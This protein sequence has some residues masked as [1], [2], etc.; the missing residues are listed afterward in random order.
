MASP[1]V[2]F[3]DSGSC[4]LNLVLGGG[5]AVG[6][7]VNICGDKAVGKTLLAVEAC[8]QFS[9]I[10]KKIEDIRY[11]ECEH[12]FNEIYG[13]QI[14]MPAG[15]TPVSD[16]QTVE[17]LFK[18]LEWFCAARKGKDRPSLYVIDSLDAL[19][20]EA[21]MKRD[22]SQGSFGA[23]KAAQLSELF[24][25]QIAIMSDANCTLLVVS[26]LRDKIGVMFGEKHSRSGGRA[27]SFYASQEI[28]LAEMKKLTR[29]IKGETRVIGARVR[30]KC[31]KNK[32]G[33]P[34]RDADLTVWFSY[35][36]DDEGSMID[37]LQEHK[38]E[39]GDVDLKE[40]NKSLLEARKNRDRKAV[41][42]INGLLRA[43]VIDHWASVEEGFQ[44]P[45]TKYA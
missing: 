4:L 21:E 39:T 33:T 45:L 38:V 29:Q 26:Q 5:Y 36:V 24:R 34:F 27:L 28:W 30:V 43:L 15:V 44:P 32:V 1:T 40:V 10:V 13:A 19:S 25:R 20:D 12:A 3:V 31:K 9:R 17:A 8:Q 16:I 2:Q 37:Y 7:V 35:G 18:D 14:G 22:I 6:R 41:A 11:I 23:A 42:G